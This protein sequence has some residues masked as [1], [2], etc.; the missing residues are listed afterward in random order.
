M[1]YLSPL[2]G[3]GGRGGKGRL[4]LDER[5]RVVEVAWDLTPLKSPVNSHRVTAI[6]VLITCQSLR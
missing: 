2:E 5:W 6:Y 3:R 1:R 4:K